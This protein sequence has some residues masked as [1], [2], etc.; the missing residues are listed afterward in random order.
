MT[1]TET[2][3]AQDRFVNVPGFRIHYVE[4]GQGHPL[5]L[6]HGS[7]P[8]ATSRTNFTANIAPLAAHFRV[9][10]IDMPGWG[11]SDTQTDE[12]GRDHVAALVGV[13]DALG[14]ERAALVGNSMGGMTSVAT[15]IHHPQRVSHLVTMGAPAPVP[16]L[17]SAANGPSEGMRVLLHAYREP[18][19]PN[20]RRLVEVMCFNPAMATDELAAARSAAALRRPDHL[21]SWNAQFTGPPTPPPYFSLGDRLREITAPTLVIHG[22]DDRVVHYENGLVLSS[23]IADSR[24]VLLNRCGHWAQIEHAEEFNRLVTSFVGAH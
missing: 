22:R 17:F 11:E 10:G 6:L 14:I 2:L 18:T 20:M 3:D 15:A 9:I 16:L 13:L 4:A 24:L 1:I 21:D 8:G 19:P 12:T 7:G 5:V 23:R